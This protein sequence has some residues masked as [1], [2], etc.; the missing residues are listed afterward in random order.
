M[1]S[2]KLFDIGTFTALHNAIVHVCIL[3]AV[4]L[5]NNGHDGLLY[6][7]SRDVLEEITDEFIEQYDIGYIHQ[8]QISTET[9]TKRKRKMVDYD[10]ERASKCVR[11]D[12]FYCLPRFNDRQFEHTFHL[13]RSMVENIVSSLADFDPFWLSSIDCCGRM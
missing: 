4:F 13:K 8:H 3:A 7:P 10:Q 2:N 1:E 11:S 9:P 6:L 12:W 5:V